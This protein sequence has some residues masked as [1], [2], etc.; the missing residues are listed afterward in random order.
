MTAMAL[1]KVMAVFAGRR[2]TGV[3]VSQAGSLG[4]GKSHK[5]DRQPPAS[6][7]SACCGWARS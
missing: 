3:A 2:G 1:R 6:A 7:T 4:F 5:Q